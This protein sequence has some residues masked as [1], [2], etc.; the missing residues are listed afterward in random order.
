MSRPYHQSLKMALRRYFNGIIARIGRRE[1]PA[2][3]STKEGCHIC[4]QP[5]L[6]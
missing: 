2:V 1:D 3:L 4:G 5:V 6:S